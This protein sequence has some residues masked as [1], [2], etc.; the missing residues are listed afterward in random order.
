MI[1]SHIR[2]TCVQT[3]FFPLLRVAV[4]TQ[5]EWYTSPKAED[6]EK[7]RKICAQQGVSAV[8][9]EFVR[10]LQK[11]N[12]PDVKTVMKW[13]ATATYVEKAMQRMML[14]A[15]EFAAEMNQRGLPV[16][17]LKGVAFAQY[18]PNP[19]HRECGDLDCYMM[20]RKEEGDAVAIEV[21]AKM[22]EAGYKH[23]HLYYKGLTI[24]NHHYFTD[25]DN[26]KCGK[27]TERLLRELIKGSCEPI[28]DT[29]LLC[30][31]AEF[32][33]L[34]LLKHA[35]GH[36]IDEGIRMR[37]VLDWG[38]FLRSQQDVVDWERMMPIIEETKIKQFAGVLT[39]IVME[40]LHIEVVHKPL[41]ALAEQADKCMVEAVL[42]DIM[43]EQPE[44]YVKGLVHKTK[45]I[46]RRF[47]RM[48]RFR[49][50][51]SESYARMVWNSFAFSS[52]FN[53]HIKED[54]N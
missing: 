9:F 15:K 20:E 26:T 40:F 27:N 5:S 4:G 39:A 37:H 17:V 33:A 22:E 1:G 11:P 50:L 19:L 35:Q 21:G 32:N 45:R 30:P 48:W 28:G 2:L 16:V 14:T 42:D 24:E 31:P 6:W 52:Y 34:F 46:M 8:V 36:F 49:S 18:Y 38:L 10:K 47:V 41:R 44:I 43:G 51:A 25:F 23:S 3:S 13:L 29:G 54:F 7:I 53:R 12:A